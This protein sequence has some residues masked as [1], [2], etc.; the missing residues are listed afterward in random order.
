MNKKFIILFVILALSLSGC[1]NNLI[2]GRQEPDKPIVEEE[3]EKEEPIVPTTTE[4]DIGPTEEEEEFVADDGQSTA[5]GVKSIAEANNKFAFDLYAKFKDK[6]GNIFFSPYSISSALTMTYEGARGKTAQEMESVFYLPKS[7]SIRRPSFARVF[8]LIN[9]EDKKYKLQTA[10]AL[11]AEESYTFLDS[12]LSLVEKYYGG[13]TTNLDFVKE[14]EKSRITIN[15]WVEEKT[16]DKIKDLIPKGVL[17]PL[18][19]LV[20]T[21]AIYFKGM[22][23]TQFENENTREEDFKTGPGSISRVSMMGLTGDEAKFNYIETD[24]MQVLE[25]LYEDEEL[26]MLILLPK[27]NNLSQTESSLNIGKLAELRA[28]LQERGV[29]VYLPKFKFETKYSLNKTLEIM[30]MPTAFS[31]Q[32]DFSGMDGTED[33]FIS[34]VIHQAFV[35][36]NEEG[37][38]AAA[39]TAVVMEFKAAPSEPNIVFRADHPF[40]FL[41]IEK[42]TDSILFMG[43]VADPSK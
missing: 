3:K 13:K 25:L 39:A 2:P 23:L 11:W 40:V 1:L 43:R 9:K 4:E 19:R 32:A 26:S 17:G 15:N 33:L 35:E 38:E 42:Q 31:T 22:W 27:G 21:N 6:G 10:N 37:T 12:Y 18:T 24:K 30:G 29:D 8:N 14:T 16:Y 7:S 5:A 41:I 20:L 34:D 36:V 28:G